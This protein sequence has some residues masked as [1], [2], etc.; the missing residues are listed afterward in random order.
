MTDPSAHAGAGQII[1]LNGT[2][3]SGKTSVAVALLKVL[4]KPYFHMS[5]DAFNSMR[6]RQRTTELSPI[7][8]SD[9]LRRTRAGFHRAVAGMAH[10]ERHRG[11]SRIQRTMASA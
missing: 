8:L 2:S 5:V 4:E 9:T 3:S 6:A 10:R 7:E 11:R 1:F